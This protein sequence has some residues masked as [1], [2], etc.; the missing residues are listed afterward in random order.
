MAKLAREESELEAAVALAFRERAQMRQQLL[1]AAQAAVR[2][3]A[4]SK[5]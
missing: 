1:E 3:V 5:E 4:L 2:V